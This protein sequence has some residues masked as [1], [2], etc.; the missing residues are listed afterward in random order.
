[1]SSLLYGKSLLISRPRY[2]EK[3]GT[4]V[5]YASVSWDGDNF[6][7]YQLKNLDKR[8]ETEEE[9]LQYGFTL[10]RQWLDEDKWD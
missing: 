1:M 5:P 6:H 7:C 4:W 3:L 8:F 9:A 10:A 2:D